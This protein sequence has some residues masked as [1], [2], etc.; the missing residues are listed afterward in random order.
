M[1]ILTIILSGCGKTSYEKSRPILNLPEMPI[2]GSKV[3]NELQNVCTKEKCNNLNEWLNRLYA[4]RVQYLI[5]KEEL[6]K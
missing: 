2:A 6:A 1:L 5:Y 4:F 3:A